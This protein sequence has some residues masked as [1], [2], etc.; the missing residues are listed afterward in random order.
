MQTSGALRAS[1]S[2]PLTGPNGA[3][4]PCRNVTVYREGYYNVTTPSD[5][6]G[7]TGR[8]PD[9]LI[10]AVD[11]L[12]GQ[13]RNA[14]PVDVPA[15]ENR[16]LWVDVLVPI[17]A[18]AGVYRGNLKLTAEGMSMDIPVELKVLS[19]TLPSTTTLKSS[20]GFTLVTT[21]TTG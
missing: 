10:P 9:P 7:A 6:E 14:F 21:T 1:F 19:F 12:L 17:D 2:V 3:V 5:L 18:A 15:G 8:W 16:T 4:I 20:F 13:T 11:P